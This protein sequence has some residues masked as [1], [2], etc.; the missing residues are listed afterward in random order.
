MPLATP[1]AELFDNAMYVPREEVE[2][3]QQ[4]LADIIWTKNLKINKMYNHVRATNKLIAVERR[5]TQDAQAA[6]RNVQ[7][8]TSALLRGADA[9][10]RGL[11]GDLIEA[12]QHLQNQQSQVGRTEVG[13][14][15]VVACSSC[16]RLN[17]VWGAVGRMQ[18]GWSRGVCS[19]VRRCQSATWSAQHNS[20]GLW[21]VGGRN[22]PSL[23]AAAP[24]CPP[25]T[26]WPLLPLRIHTLPSPLSPAHTTCS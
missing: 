17:G 18:C 4:E 11:R 9:E 22:R 15:V 25:N 6:I 16:C 24:L 2:E 10:I 7:D 3:M 14:G 12:Y 5:H 20:V 21:G 19:A 26:H 23:I 13:A 1:Q 8:H